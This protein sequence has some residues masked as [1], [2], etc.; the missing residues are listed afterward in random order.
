MCDI[1]SFEPVD[2]NFVPLRMNNKIWKPQEY[3]LSEIQTYLM[4][5]IK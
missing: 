2:A 5:K 4:P 3:K 1:L